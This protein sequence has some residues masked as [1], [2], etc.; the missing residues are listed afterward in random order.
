MGLVVLVCF[1]LSGASG[2]IFEVLWTRELGLVFGSTTLAMSTV[3]AAFMGGLALG[4]LGA[5]RIVSRVRD[6]LRAYALCEAGVGLY[7][8]L[9]PVLLRLYPA[10]NALFFRAVGEHHLP[11]TLLRFAAA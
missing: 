4:S 9:I 2:L 6:P 3:L 11:L 1:F 8:L 10:L 7:A 5:G